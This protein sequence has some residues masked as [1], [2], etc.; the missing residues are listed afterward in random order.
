MYCYMYSTCYIEAFLTAC[1]SKMTKTVQRTA[2]RQQTK[3]V[4]AIAADHA[5]EQRLMLWP[6]QLIHLTPIVSACYFEH[7]SSQAILFFQACS[8]SLAKITKCSLYSTY[9][10]FSDSGLAYWIQQSRQS[11]IVIERSQHNYWTMPNSLVGTIQSCWQCSICDRHYSILAVVMPLASLDA[12]ASFHSCWR[13]LI[14]SSY[15]FPLYCSTV[16]LSFNHVGTISFLFASLE[17]VSVT[18]FLLSLFHPVAIT[19]FLSEPFYHSAVFDSGCIIQFLACSKSCW[20]L[21]CVTL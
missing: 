19:R 4:P 13:C 9:T 16:L 14:L 5:S 1:L 8:T 17:P 21:P 18:Q 12:I 15:L 11:K 6:W 7:L 3:S 2:L 10:N 20:R